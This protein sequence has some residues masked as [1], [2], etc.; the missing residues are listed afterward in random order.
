MSQCKS[1]NVNFTHKIAQHVMN[2]HCNEKQSN[3][4]QNETKG[5]K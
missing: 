3:Q 5:N 4:N 1:N 2:N